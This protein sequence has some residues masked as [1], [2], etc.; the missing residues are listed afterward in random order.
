LSLDIQTFRVANF[1]QPMEAYGK[2][3]KPM[4][5]KKSTAPSARRIS[6]FH[7]T[8]T[9]FPQTPHKPKQGYTNLNK[10]KQG[11]FFSNNPIPTNLLAFPI[12]IPSGFPHSSQC[13]PHFEVGCSVLDV[14]PCIPLPR[15]AHQSI[16]PS[17]QVVS[18]CWSVSFQ[19]L[20]LAKK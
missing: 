11:N 9:P 7:H 16:N 10:V 4:E 20:V 6:G 13:L 5:T 14:G 17:S 15:P 8:G 19:M 18:R 3:R 12:A 1:L 2:S